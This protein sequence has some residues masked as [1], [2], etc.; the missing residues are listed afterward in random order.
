[1]TTAIRQAR[2]QQ[3]GPAITAPVVTRILPMA[4]GA[5]RQA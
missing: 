5:L 3:A 1:M 4:T 2:S